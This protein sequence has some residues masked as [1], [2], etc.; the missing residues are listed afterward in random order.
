MAIIGLDYNTSWTWASDNINPTVAVRMLDSSALIHTASAGEEVTSVGF[1]TNNSPTSCVVEIGLYNV[2]SGTN[3]ATLEHYTT[4][5]APFSVAAWNSKSVSWSLTAGQTYA[6]AIGCRSINTGNLNTVHPGYLG[7]SASVDNTNTGADGLPGDDL[8]PGGTWA[9][10]VNSYRTA[11]YA[12]TA[13]TA[14]DP[15]ISMAD[16]NGNTDLVDGAGDGVSADVYWA[17]LPG[18]TLDAITAIDTHG[19]A[20]V[21]SGDVTMTLVGSSQISTTAG[22]MMVFSQTD[23]MVFG[24]YPVEVD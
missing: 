12:E 19:A 18:A 22:F 5:S 3:G 1:Y 2:T 14:A 7:S 10:S 8:D 9:D 11:V 15:T 21:T 23:P 20:T 13:I 17:F 24:I 16:A 6:V 4:M